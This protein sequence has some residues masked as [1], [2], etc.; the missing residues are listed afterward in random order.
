MRKMNP[1]SE[2]AGRDEARKDTI[3][4]EI[5]TIH[6]KLGHLD[7]ATT[8][9]RKITPGAWQSGFAAREIA[10]QLGVNATDPMT[11]DEHPKF[12]RQELERMR[13]A[14]TAK[15]AL[16]LRYWRPTNWAFMNGDRISQPSSRDHIESRIRWLPAEVQRYLA[17]I[18]KQERAI[19][20]QADAIAGAP[21]KK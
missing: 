10:R 18:D 15:N 12:Q 1:P 7:A 6:A 9:L 8:F 4:V 14:I 20:E 21:T 2:P 19:A 11:D 13:T 5:A 17:I 3:R 16:W